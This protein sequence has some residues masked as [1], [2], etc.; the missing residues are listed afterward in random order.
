MRRVQAYSPKEILLKR[1]YIHLQMLSVVKANFTSLK[2]STLKRLFDLYD[3]I[4]FGGEI[5]EKLTQDNSTLTMSVT[6]RKGVKY[7]GYCKKTAKGT[8]CFYTLQFPT[9][10]FMSLFNKGEKGLKNGGL[11]CKNRL[12][13]LQLT[14]E[15]ELIHLLMFLWKFSGKGP[16]YSSHGKLFKCMVYAYFGQTEFKHSLLAGDIASHLTRA[17]LNV[18]TIVRVKDAGLGIVRGFTSKKVRVDI[19]LKDGRLSSGLASLSSLKLTN[20]ILVLPSYLKKS[21]ARVG[22]KVKFNFKK[23]AVVGT[24][25]KINPTK[26]KVKANLKG[27]PG[28][29]NIPWTSLHRV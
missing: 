6:N 3:D 11:I 1:E 28:I 23:E 4:F 8:R 10:V 19:L 22:M 26:G 15:H 9:S 27:K 14:F 5:Q 21:S 12:D 7:G 20:E 17:D 18:G 25:I 2:T 24:L 29:F 16:V 13:C